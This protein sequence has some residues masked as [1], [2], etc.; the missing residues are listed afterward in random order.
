MDN[1]M[2]TLVSNKMPREFPLDK[3]LS[4]NDTSNEKEN[5]SFEDILGLIGHT[6][7]EDKEVSE[8]ISIDL[9]SLLKQQQDHNSPASSR[10]AIKTVDE[11]LKKMPVELQEKL[12]SQDPGELVTDI[13]LEDLLALSSAFSGE[14]ASLQN[15]SDFKESPLLNQGDNTKLPVS[16]GFDMGL[17]QLGNKKVDSSISKMEENKILAELWNKAKGIL[18]GLINSDKPPNKQQEVQLHRIMEQWSK[19]EKQA[20]GNNLP[21]LLET[22]D[23]KEKK[24]AMTW[25]QILNK[26]EKRHSNLNLQKY[27]SDAVITSKE[28]GKWI[29]QALSKYTEEQKFSVAPSSASTLHLPMSKIEQYIVHVNNTGNQDQLQKSLIDDFQSVLKSSSFMKEGGS[30]ELLLK[31][32]PAQLGEVLVK[33]TQ[34]NGEMI[35][36]MTVTTAAAKEMLEGSMHQLRPMFSPHQIVIEKQDSQLFQQDF[37]YEAE[38]ESDKEGMNQSFKDDTEQSSEEKSEDGEGKEEV[39]HQL[40]MNEKAQV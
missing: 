30:T 33:L 39:F 22:V 24:L 26:F 29:S 4:Q 36:K 27:G 3:N 25:S 35:V 10:G 18:E 23:G 15:S 17:L 20:T 9:T 32:R 21:P 1:G 2:L 16:Q 19:L 11:L 12:M 14:S 28:I 31:L 8:E 37:T 40:L 7:L 5:L 6:S 38:R 34:T 13:P